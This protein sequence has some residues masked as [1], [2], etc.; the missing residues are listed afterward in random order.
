SLL[1]FPRRSFVE[2]IGAPSGR[3]DCMS[4]TTGVRGVRWAFLCFVLGASGVGAQDTYPARPVRYIAPFP[5]GG[6]SDV[7]SRIIAQKLTESLGRQVIVEN[8]PGAGSNIGHEVVA[9][10]PPDGY[11]LLMSSNT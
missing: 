8:R 6:T 5:A 2:R 7:L 9:K 10:A 1:S 3:N 4:F 11:T